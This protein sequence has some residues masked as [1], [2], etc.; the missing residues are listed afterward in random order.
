MSKAKILAALTEYGTRHWD[1]DKIDI[2][3]TGKDSEL[4]VSGEQGFRVI[5]ANKD[6]VTIE[7]HCGKTVPGQDVCLNVGSKVEANDKKYAKRLEQ[8]MEVAQE[9]VNG[10]GISGD[11]TGDDWYLY[12]TRS[13]TVPWR[14]EKGKRSYKVTAEAI[15]EAVN[16]AVEPWEEQMGYLNEGIG[17]AAGWRT[18]TGRKRK[19]LK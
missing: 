2:C 8:Y 10:C 15:I 14:T 16:K 19:A 11:W 4:E 9:L 18:V 7:I 6:G 17:Q 12:E 3:L 13:F 5:K 1:Y